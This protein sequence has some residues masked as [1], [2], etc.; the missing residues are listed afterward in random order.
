MS[1]PQQGCEVK[2][3]MRLQSV[4]FKMWTLRKSREKTWKPKRKT[5]KALVSRLS[6]YR[7]MLKTF[8]G[9]VMNDWGSFNSLFF[10]VQ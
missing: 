3:K 10:V 8:L 2:M 1:H 5:N 4:M 9:D 7:C 6:F